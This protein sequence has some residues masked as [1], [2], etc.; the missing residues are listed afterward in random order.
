MHLWLNH[1]DRTCDRVA[2]LTL[3][4]VHRDHGG[5]HCIHQPLTHFQTIAVGN[6]RVGHQVAHIAHQHQ[7]AALCGDSGAI[8]CSEGT[9]SCHFTGDG[10]TTF[11][12]RFF[13][14]ATHEAKPVGVCNNFVF[15]I[16]G[17]DTIFAVHDRGQ[18]GLKPNIRDVSLISLTNWCGPIDANFDQQTIFAQVV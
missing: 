13:Q 5:H 16:Y 1:I 11:F 14:I 7:G 15:S 4:V 3:Q 9:V 17:C 10:L 6:C 8:G 12:E 18:C 2:A